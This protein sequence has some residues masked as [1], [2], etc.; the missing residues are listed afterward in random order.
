VKSSS[1]ASKPN[2]LVCPI[3]EVGQL[4]PSGHGS[5]RCESCSTLLGEAFLEM[6]QQ[7][8][9]LPD[10]VGRHACE[11]GH[12]EMRHLPDGTY[13]CPACGLEILPIDAF[14][15]AWKSNDRSKAYWAGWL[16]GRFG[17]PGLFTSN[18]GLARWQSAHDRLDYYR[19]HRD[20]R[21]NR[22]ERRQP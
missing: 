18:H 8:T 12:P 22:S 14:P 16:D 3:C 19:G 5:T 6:L 10:V 20:G 7:I 1:L 9:E 13:H 15:V 4:R 2:A 17:E 21:E 11:C